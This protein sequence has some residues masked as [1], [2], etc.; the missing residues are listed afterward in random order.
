MENYK[1]AFE[2]LISKLEN[3]IL[4]QE[5]KKLKDIDDIKTISKE[6]KDIEGKNKLNK[7]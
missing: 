7:N 3:E 5:N 4:I 2:K 6:I 1:Y